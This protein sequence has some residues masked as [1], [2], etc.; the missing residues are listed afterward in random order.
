MA[1][2][3]RPAAEAGRDV[4]AR[5]P[6]LDRRHALAAFVAML[7]TSGAA[8]ALK[9]THRMADELPPLD[10][11]RQVPRSFDGWREDTTV[12]PLLPDPTLQAKLDQLYT[13]LLARTYV[14]A[15]GR[16][17]ML[18]VAYGS[19]QSSEVTSV[20]RP[21]FCYGAQGFRV[22]DAGVAPLALPGRTIA[23]RHLVAQMGPRYEPIVYWITLGDEAS[24]PGWGRKLRQLRYGLGGRIPDGM[25][26]RSSTVGLEDDESFPLQ[27]AFFQA[28]HARID[29]TL[30]PRF[31][32]R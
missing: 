5:G 10:L 32:G 6:D 9:P 12:A 30:R 16:R 7:G 17:V 28:L 23:T 27:Q 8:W 24:L 22:R 29:P 2:A 20:H 14:D 31:F 19:D 18:T 21:E 11:A 1:E 4:T 13:Q 3:D 15:A 26:V 25:L